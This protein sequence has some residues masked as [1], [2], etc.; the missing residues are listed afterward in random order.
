MG[1]QY[2][3]VVTSI[4]NSMSSITWLVF[5]ERFVLFDKIIED[6]GL[7]RNLESGRADESTYAE[8]LQKRCKML[9]QYIALKM[10]RLEIDRVIIAKP[11]LKIDDI[12]LYEA[13]IER[14]SEQHYHML[15]QELKKGGHDA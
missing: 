8:R 10:L 4:R 7:H 5:F 3:H 12:A 6:R 11:A 14:A 13:L 2:D 15:A 9:L 1:E